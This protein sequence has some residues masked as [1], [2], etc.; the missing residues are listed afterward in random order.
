M[1]WFTLF[2]L[3][4]KLCI[5]FLKRGRKEKARE[6]EDLCWE[7]RVRRRRIRKKICI[8][9]DVVEEGLKRE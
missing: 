6:Q 7:K 3:R 4:L 8:P 9:K 2:V 5:G 1:C